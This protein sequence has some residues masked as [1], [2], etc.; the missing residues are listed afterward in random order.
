VVDDHTL[1][2][3]GISALLRL[4]P[5][6]EVVGEAADGKEALAKVMELRPE[7]VLMDLEM[8]VMDGLEAS[9]KICARYPDVAVLVLSQYQDAE[10]VLEAV[11]A[12]VKGFVNKNAASAELATAIRSVHGGDSYL[13]PAAAR[14]LIGE[15]RRSGSHRSGDPYD[16]LTVREKE[17][18][19]LIAQGKTTRQIADL[20]VV[21]PKTVEGH[22]TRLMAKLGVHDRVE[23]VKFAVRKGI[24]TV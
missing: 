1:L 4:A 23:L 17:I 14:L 22:R 19:K 15:V 13:S 7:V 6:M 9:R 21:S 20:L 18:L 11:E 10:H 8:P 24:I 16:S 12:G 5:D 2:R 3:D